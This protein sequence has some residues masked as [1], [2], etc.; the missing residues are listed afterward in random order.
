M[1]DQIQFGSKTAQ[2]NIFRVTLKN[3]RNAWRWR[4]RSR[5][6]TSVLY[7][8][9]GH[10]RCACSSP[11]WFAFL[12]ASKTPNDRCIFIPEPPNVRKTDH[13]RQVWKNIR[14]WKFRSDGGKMQSTYMVTTSPLPGDDSAEVILNTATK[15]L[16]RRRNEPPSA[17]NLCAI[18]LDLTLRNWKLHTALV[19][20]KTAL[21]FCGKI[22]G[23]IASECLFVY[24]YPPSNFRPTSVLQIHTW[25]H[26]DILNNCHRSPFFLD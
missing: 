18:S 7:D 17:L 6:C 21:L 12:R 22:W 25:Y 19:L 23:S 3:E 24:H 1:D 14:G 8:I 9:I 16:G 11:I 4:W 20:Y 13:L 10:P 5:A 26:V 15:T 2:I